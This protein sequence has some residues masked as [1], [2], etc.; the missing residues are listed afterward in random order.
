MSQLSFRPD[1]RFTIVQFTD[2][3][4]AGDP[5]DVMT[6]ELMGRVIE[7]ER[8]DL[9]F[10]TG[11][12]VHPSTEENYVEL[13]HGVVGFL[14]S[15]A[16]PWTFIFG[17]HDPETVGYDRIEEIMT[18]SSLCLYESGSAD[19]SG[20]GNFCLPIPTYDGNRDA[21]LLWGLDSGMGSSEPSGYDWVK[22][23]QVA[24]FAGEWDR[25]M[26]DASDPCTSLMF[27]H[28]PLQQYNEV[29]DTQACRGYKYEG[30]CPQGKDVGLFDA[31]K[32][33]VT[34]CFAGHEHVNDYEGTLDGVDLV[35]G[36]GGG[37][38]AY[39]RWGYLHGARVI[40]LRE[41][42]QG[43]ASHIRLADGSRALR[44]LHQPEGE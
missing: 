12:V 24:W 27:F 19:I 13:W 1:G 22:E 18:A 11:D 38:R 37:Y 34:A 21:A 35:Y 15:K 28:N 9:V 25:R 42:T 4:L 7:Q 3:H 32:G 14:E 6:Y 16:I 30:V 39:G 43:Y 44:P 10:L 17:N 33:R 29:W 36:R 5:R 26:A 20:H 31:M 8:P 41:D 40:E 2:T 23:D